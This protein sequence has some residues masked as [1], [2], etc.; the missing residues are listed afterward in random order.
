MRDDFFI[1][2][3]IERPFDLDGDFRLIEDFDTFKIYSKNKQF[4]S[5]YK[6]NDYCVVSKS[7]IFNQKIK[8]S[9]VDLNYKFLKLFQLK[10]EKFAEDLVGKFSI[11]IIDLKNNGIIFCS[12]HLA[13]YPIYF[14]AKDDGFMASTELEPITHFVQKKLD[15]EVLKDHLVQ[16]TPRIGRTIY[17]DINVQAPGTYSQLYKSQLKNVRYHTFRYQEHEDSSEIEFK[18]IFLNVIKEQINA[19]EGS[20]SFSLSGGIDSSSIVCGAYEVN[21]SKIITHSALFPKS[22]SDESYYIEKVLE[23]VSPQ[24]NSYSWI[25][26]DYLEQLDRG[27]YFD[28]IAFGVSTYINHKIYTNTFNNGIKAHFEGIYGDE[29]I[30]HGYERLISLGLSFNFLELF[31]QEKILRSN[32]DLEFSYIRSLKDNL[33]RPIIPIGFQRLIF[34]KKRMTNIFPWLEIKNKDFNLNPVDQ[35][36]SINGYHPFL[37]DYVS[38]QS[39]HEKSLNS[40][41]LSYSARLY[42]NIGKRYGLELMSL[43]VT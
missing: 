41:V 36:I 11:C 19:I 33:L 16:N 9:N 12:D 37:K 23:K 42:N 25:D 26:F 20:I 2:H 24:H 10:K 22:K 4:N 5:I 8:G 27:S 30:S 38:Y 21:K 35:F 13:H 18:E 28:E 29:V 17:K 1:T 15:F 14:S 3:N 6:N 40:A 7:L 43:L 34:E 39:N 31:R 32:K